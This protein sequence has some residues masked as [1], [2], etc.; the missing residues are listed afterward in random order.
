MTTK[1]WLL[2]I[3]RAVEGWPTMPKDDVGAMFIS[4]PDDWV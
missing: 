4:T 1:E 2:K 3:A